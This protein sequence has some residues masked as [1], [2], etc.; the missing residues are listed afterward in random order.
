MGKINQLKNGVYVS[1]HAWTTTPD[2]VMKQL[3][4]ARFELYDPKQVF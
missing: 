1:M 4:N 2:N 3:A